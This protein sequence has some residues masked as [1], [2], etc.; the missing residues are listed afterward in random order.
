MK[1]FVIILFVLFVSFN[2]E[3]IPNGDCDPCLQ[4]SGTAEDPF[5]IND[6]DDLNEF[7]N[8][9][10]TACATNYYEG[11]I[12]LTADIDCNVEGF[13][14]S[15]VDFSGHFEGNNYTISNFTHSNTSGPPYKPCGFFQEN[16]GTIQ[17][18]NLG[19]V[20][21]SAIEDVGG[22]VGYNFGAIL[23]CHV[24][25]TVKGMRPP[26]PPIRE[27]RGGTSLSG[28]N[29]GGLF[30]TNTGYVKNSSSS[31]NVKSFNCAGGLGGRNK[32]SSSDEEGLIE[33]SF[34]T[35][36]VSG[37]NC[38]GGLIGM[39]QGICEDDLGD[40]VEQDEQTEDPCTNP[41]LGINEC[42]ATGDVSGFFS[43]NNYPNSIG[44]LVGYNSKSIIKNSYCSGNVT[45]TDNN[46]RDIG[47]FVGKAFNNN[48]LYSYSKG[49]VTGS[50]Y[51]GGF[52]GNIN[53]AAFTCCYWNTTPNSGLSG[54][55]N[56]PVP[57]SITGIPSSSFSNMSTMS[58]LF[59]ANNNN[60]WTM[61]A[62]GPIL[63]GTTV[64]TLT[65]WATIAFIG[66]LAIIG[67]VFIWRKVV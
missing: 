43:M 60:V 32:K 61:G 64:P 58:C 50:G 9:C 18:L 41:S 48:V 56:T 33:N 67:G 22:L 55:G 3:M 21:V 30:G 65:E 7:F 8:P 45:G 29:I 34:A 62:G 46:S 42:F 6:I 26:P 27:L 14:P 47:G 31:C 37:N 11:Y 1:K 25:G 19:N 38:V 17:N 24:S 39:N 40:F 63:L 16:S 66:L 15:N 49:K 51:V 10:T 36:S 35:G 4:G 54:S 28:S 20:N 44:G 5:I 12:E 23:N 53:G 59:T 13:D 57:S 2:V 52:V